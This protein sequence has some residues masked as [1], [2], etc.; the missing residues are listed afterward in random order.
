MQAPWIDLI[1]SEWRD[2]RDGR[3]EDR[4]TQLDWVSSFLRKWGFESWNLDPADASAALVP[5]RGVLRRI[6]ESLDKRELPTAADLAALN[7]ILG[8]T[9]V[10]RRLDATEDGFKYRVEPARRTPAVIAAEI[11]AGFAEQ[12]SSSDTKRIRICC[13]DNCRW[14]FF[15]ES[16]NR[17]RRW[18]EDETCG[19]LM[20]VRRFRSR[21]SA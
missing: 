12:L 5:V 13:N 11:A 20:R 4:L 1:N 8:S 7:D 21:H 10:L 3:Y 14:V 15:D 9:P 2:H 6:S 16:R 18:C 19:N 17:R